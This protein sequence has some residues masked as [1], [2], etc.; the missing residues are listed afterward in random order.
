MSSDKPAD[1]GE[2]MDQYSNLDELSRDFLKELGNIGTGNA[3]TALSQMLLEPVDIEVPE[4][5]IMKYQDCCSLLR[6]AEEHH[7]GTRQRFG[8]RRTQSAFPE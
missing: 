8:S 5:Q 1:K 3:V 7:G 6:S 4:L 2:A